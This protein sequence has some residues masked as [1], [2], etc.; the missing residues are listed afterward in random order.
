MVLTRLFGDGTKNGS[1]G[2]LS[3]KELPARPKS[4]RRDVLTPV[5]QLHPLS[6][7]DG[8]FVKIQPPREPADPQLN[9]VPCDLVLCIDVSGSMGTRAPVPTRP[10]EEQ[11]EVGLSVLDLVKHAARTIMETLD[12]RDRLGI[13]TFA[14]KSKASQPFSSPLGLSGKCKKAHEMNEHSDNEGQ[15]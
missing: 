9:H 15:L 11:E 5:V 10:G 6:S 2:G 14:S 4:Q 12:P 3:D 7:G 1:G 8:I 13:V